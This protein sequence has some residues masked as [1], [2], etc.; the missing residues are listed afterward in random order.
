[1]AAPC[2]RSALALPALLLS[3][4]ALAACG[5][6]ASAELPS[7]A[8]PLDSDESEAVYQLN[9]IR[10]GMSL[11][12]VKSC[13]TL[14][15]SASAHSDDLRDNPELPLGIAGSDGSDVRTRACKDG[16]AAAC[17]TTTS[18]GEVVARGYNTGAD[19]V[20]GW[21]TDPTAEPI[22][23]NPQLIAVGV[24]RSQ[25]ADGWY[26]TMDSRERG[27]SE[28]RDEVR[29]GREALPRQR[30]RSSRSTSG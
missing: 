20:T 4:L 2:F 17:S 5:T 7:E 6:V 18:M 29:A 21:S 26:Y 16:Y 27:R 9:T 10:M 13:F 15:V 3:T 22:V 28:L 14:N 30:A 1:M 24:G 23:L 25:G 19:D 11:P 8:N 12:P